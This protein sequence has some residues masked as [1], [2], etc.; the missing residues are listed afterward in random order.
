MFST[1]EVINKQIPQPLVK[2]HSVED[3]IGAF[4]EVFAKATGA[5]QGEYTIRLDRNAQP[6]QHTPRRVPLAIR[7]KVCQKLKELE[8]NGIIQQITKPTPW[9]SSMVEV[10]KPNGQLRICLDPR[11]LNKAIQR[12][13][14]PLP[15]IEEVATRLHGAKVF[16]KLDVRNGFWHIKLKEESSELTAFHTPFGRY[17]LRRLPF[18]LCSA[19]EVFQ[20]RMHEVIEGL[21]GVE[22]IADDFLVVG[23][24]EDISAAVVDHDRNI[25]AFLIRCKEKM[26]FSTKRS[27]S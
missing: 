22:V 24:G 20:R 9:I 27:S 19:P 2:L 17:C 7:D 1:E 15:T 21:T 3:V 8:E 6:V 14:Y 12:E 11:D 5:M 18:G 13:K 25:Y 26:S 23:Y 10:V 4:P 16:T